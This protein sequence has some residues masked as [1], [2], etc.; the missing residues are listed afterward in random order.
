MKKILLI[1]VPLLAFIGGAFGGDLLG[2]GKTPTETASADSAEAHEAGAESGHGTAEAAGHGGGHDKATLE[3]DWFKFPNQFFVPVIRNG[4]TSAVMILSLSLE[5]EGT[6]R[7][8]VETRE[9]SLRDALLNA[10]MSAANPGAFDGNFTAEPGLERLRAELLVAAQRVSGA[11]VK[12][13]LIEDIG[14]QVQ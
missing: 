3:M 8:D 13:V 14:R 5:I 6:A 10:L 12:R 2:A 7:A 4:T 1:L 11:S 9:H